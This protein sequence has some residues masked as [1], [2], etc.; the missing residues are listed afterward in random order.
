[1]RIL[2]TALSPFALAIAASP[3]AA[4][5]PPEIA[6]R[7]R[8]RLCLPDSARQAWLAPR[9]QFVRG[10][11]TAVARDT[12]YFVLHGTQ[13]PV[14]VPRSA[15]RR[16]DRSLGVPPGAESALRGAVAGAFWG[17]VYWAVFQDPGSHGSY[18]HLGDDAAVGAGVGFLLGAISPTER[19]RRVRLR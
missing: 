19:W 7:T 11:V 9:Q 5:F 4:Q 16:L 12:L 13:T 14:A 2:L 8:V 15:I 10:E 1:M 17:A 18:R 6:P 3:L